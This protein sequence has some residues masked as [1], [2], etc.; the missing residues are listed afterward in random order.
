M[1]IF[2]FVQLNAA[3]LQGVLSLIDCRGQSVPDPL[4]RFAFN[5]MEIEKAGNEPFG[6]LGRV[7]QFFQG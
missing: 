5:R 3:R 6:V 7:K 2:G 1:L 4:E